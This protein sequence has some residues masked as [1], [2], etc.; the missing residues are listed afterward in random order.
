MAVERKIR[1]ALLKLRSLFRR[2]RVEQ[3]LDEELAFHLDYLQREGI[4]RGLS[5]QEARRQARLALEGTDRTK[6]ECRDMRGIT[7]IEHL[8]QDLRYGWR[9]LRRDAGFAAIAIATLAVGIGANTAIFSALDAALLRPLPY[10]EPE[11]IV[12]IWETTPR[13]GRNSVCGGA[14]LD[15]REQSERIESIALVGEVAFNLR[16]ED[17][18]ELLHGFEASHGFL[19]V[20]GVSPLLG[21]GFEPTDE[22]AGG[23]NDVVLLT[24]QAWRS[25]FQADESI[26]GESLILDEKPYTVIGV[27]PAVARIVGEAAFFVPAVLNPGDGGRSSRGGNHFARVFAR[28]RPGVSAAEI[29]AELQAVKLRL[30]SDYPPYKQEW[31]VAATPLHESLAEQPRPILLV[32]AGAVA[33]V[34]LIACANVA[35]L[36][37]ARA[38][39]RRREIAVRAALGAQGGRIVR[40][41]FAE[42][43]L[44]AGLGGV[45]GI[46]V[47]VGGIR[48]LGR[49][50]GDLLPGLLTPQLDLRVLAASIALTAGTSLLFG[51][52]PAWKA[53]R[54]DLRKVLGEG[55]RGVTGSRSRSQS[56]LVA[57]EMALTVVLLV[58]AGLFLRSLVN[59]TSVDPGFVAEGAF[60]FDLSLP[61]RGYPNEESRNAYIRAVLERTA[62]LPGVAAVAASSGSPLAGGEFNNYASRE[63]RPEMRNDFLATINY[64]SPGYFSTLGARMVRGRALRDADNRREAARAAVIDERLAKTLFPGENPMGRFV[65]SS[66]GAWE[67]VGVVADLGIS[68]YQ[69]EEGSLFLPQ[70]YFPFRLSMVV[71]ARSGEP[72]AMLPEI[73]REIQSLDAGI[74]L[75]NVRTLEAALA[76]VHEVRRVTLGLIAGLAATALAL[77]C[78]GLYG[79]MAYTVAM[80]RRELS[81]RLALGATRSQVVGLIVR[82]GGR[83]AAFGLAAGALAAVAASRL[84]ASQL[85]EVSAA[86]PL[87]LVSAVAILG[88]VGVLSSWL[89]A[90][91]ATGVEPIA[92]LRED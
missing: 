11:R 79:V 33:L 12:E 31:G 83:L 25:R 74:P 39:T 4:A 57:G 5:P 42:S 70:A 6:E 41:V 65:S 10:P 76:G 91:R 86:D 77:A 88:I 15:W 19:D 60:T 55:D 9:G 1:S 68:R 8:A 64:V 17:G 56:L 81:I 53:R 87:A 46:A 67:I 32:L 84:F 26:L 78:M 13:W 29:E 52:L 85:H 62:A 37:L 3:E 28:V 21:R 7:F 16:T 43:V 38:V 36:L 14:F 22:V 2:E 58:A 72:L 30:A 82:D 27:T 80:R 47:A 75:S 63:D 45:C 92:A 40:Q 48:L 44:L 54:P 49:W 66:G 59:L 24:E 34:L 18:A 89:P 69:S 90:R 61:S 73:Q 50:T 35:N 23:A 51:L 71:R 20:L